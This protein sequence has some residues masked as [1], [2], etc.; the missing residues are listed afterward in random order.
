ML[1]IAPVSLQERSVAAVEDVVWPMVPSPTLWKLGESLPR[2]IILV[3]SC[4]KE[5]GP[6][7]NEGRRAAFVPVR[8]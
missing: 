6:I 8:K 7:G 2:H 5:S 4:Q 3:K 1:L